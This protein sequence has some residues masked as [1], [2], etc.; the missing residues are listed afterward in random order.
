MKL[1]KLFDR[2]LLIIRSISY[3]KFLLCK[4]FNSNNEIISQQINNNKKKLSNHYFSLYL[5]LPALEPSISRLLIIV[6]PG[7]GT[8]QVKVVICLFV[9]GFSIEVDVKVPLCNGIDMSYA[10]A[11]SPSTVSYKTKHFFSVEFDF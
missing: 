6:I 3:P 8:P 10:K 11:C 1:F 4:N 5:F 9:L 2:S 7:T